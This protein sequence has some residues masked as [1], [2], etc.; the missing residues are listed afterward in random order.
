MSMGAAMCHRFLN[1]V[2]REYLPHEIGPVMGVA[3]YSDNDEQK[4][5]RLD[6]YGYTYSGE[7]DL[8]RGHNGGLMRP[9]NLARLDAIRAAN[10]AKRQARFYDEGAEVTEEQWIT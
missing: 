7:L 4:G 3:V 2:R 6:R 5:S 1:G 9:E 8:V 10:E